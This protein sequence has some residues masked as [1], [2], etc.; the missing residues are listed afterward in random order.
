MNN[1]ILKYASK[2]YVVIFVHLAKAIFN[3]FYIFILEMLSEIIQ[4]QRSDYT[5]IHLIQK[6][7]LYVILYI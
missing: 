6:I 7:I 5:N 3:F 2:D 4:N 1:C